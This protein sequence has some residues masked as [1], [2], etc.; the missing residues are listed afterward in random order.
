MS[1]VKHNQVGGKKKGLDKEEY[2]KQYGVPKRKESKDVG[3]AA[4]GKKSGPPP[5][6]GPSSEG[7]SFTDF[8]RS[9]VT[10]KDKKGNVISK[11]EMYKEDEMIDA[12]VES[13][14]E[15]S[16]REMLGKRKGGMMTCPNRPD[17]VRG[18]GAAIKGTKFSGLK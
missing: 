2:R 1:G 11:E 9:G 8:G 14:L 18:V 10:Y 3:A 4:L 16:T 12:P 6:K 15:E 13:I 17:G 7:V 5:S